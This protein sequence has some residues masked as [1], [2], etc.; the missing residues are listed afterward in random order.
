MTKSIAKYVNHSIPTC[1]QIS[2]NKVADFLLDPTVSCIITMYKRK[3]LEYKLQQILTLS[4][5]TMTVKSA[6]F[7][8]TTF[9]NNFVSSKC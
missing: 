2:C 3:P 9:A 4:K 8:L 6:V 5:V 7:E 1:L